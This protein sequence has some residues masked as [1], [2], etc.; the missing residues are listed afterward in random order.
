M[1]SIGMLAPVCLCCI[2]CY[3]IASG[4]FP[5]AVVS[6]AALSAQE[7]RVASRQ[8]THLDWLRQYQ[9]ACELLEREQAKIEEIGKRN[10]KECQTLLEDTIRST[11]TKDFQD[12]WDRSHNPKLMED[13]T[14]KKLALSENDLKAVEDREEKT[15]A[16]FNKRIEFLQDG[17][18]NPKSA[19]GLL[20]RAAVDDLPSTRQLKG[21]RDFVLKLRHD[22]DEARGA[23]MRD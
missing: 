15:R 13:W 4:P 22:R 6:A 21:Q 16:A 2:L 12:M 9:I 3:Q 14:A 10:D 5:S 20:Y 18:N 23:L 7:G 8:A 11:L 1:R 17:V 19:L